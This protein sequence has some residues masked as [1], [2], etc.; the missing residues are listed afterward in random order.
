MDI[1]DSLYSSNKIIYLMEMGSVR[2]HRWI[3]KEN[4]TG[5]QQ[6]KLWPFPV[7]RP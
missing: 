5:Q 3:Y 6:L 4:L 1:N 7:T 2:Q